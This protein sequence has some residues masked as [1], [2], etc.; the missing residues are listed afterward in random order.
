MQEVTAACEQMADRFQPKTV[1][2]AFHTKQPSSQYMI[3]IILINSE[4]SKQTAPYE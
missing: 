3:C 1:L 4:K 2:W